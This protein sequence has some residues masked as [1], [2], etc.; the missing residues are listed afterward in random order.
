VLAHPIG[1]GRRKVYIASTDPEYGP[2]Q[3]ARDYVR[4]QPGWTWREI[5][6]GHDSMVTA[7]ARLAELL[8]EIE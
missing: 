5:A 7:P 6:T 1:N 3:P 8:L 2:L 4:A